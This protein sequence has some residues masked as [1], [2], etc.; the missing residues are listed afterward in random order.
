MPKTKTIEPTTEQKILS[1]LFV[2]S[3]VHNSDTPEKEF[4][5]AVADVKKVTF[6][7]TI[8]RMKKPKGLIQYTLH[9]K[10]MKLTD[11][12]RDE[13]AKLALKD[14]QLTLKDDLVTTNEQHHVNIK[15]KL[16]P[17][18]AR[19]AFEYLSDGREYNKMDVMGAI[20]CTN[21]NT[22]GHLLSKMLKKPGY[23]EYRGEKNM[24][25]TNLCFPF[26]RP[27]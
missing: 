24:R 7:P 25:L 12:G 6:Y 4:V 13:A 17:G 26:G 1:A 10:T 23:I 22:F 16:S 2:F 14:D 19:N 11:K 9:Q 18:L 5:R 15:K 27:S 8:S 20:K 3:S 21:R